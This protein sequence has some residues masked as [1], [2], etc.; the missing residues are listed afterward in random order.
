IV[1]FRM[2]KHAHDDVFSVLHFI[3]RRQGK[4]FLMGGQTV[5][6]LSELV[7]H[8]ADRNWSDL[9][10]TYSVKKREQFIT[11][12]EYDENV[13]SKEDKSLD[14]GSFGEVFLGTLYRK[15]VALK[16][17]LKTNVKEEEFL[18]EAEIARHCKHPNVLE[19]IGICRSKLCIITEYMANGSLKQYMQKHKLAHATCKSVA[20]KVASAMEFLERRKIVHRDLAA[21]NILVGETIEIIKVADFGLA[22]SLDKKSFY[23][24]Y[25]EDFPYLW[26]APEGFV[27]T[28]S[29]V[30]T[31]KSSVTNALDVWSFGVIMW[32]LYT[33]GLQKPYIGFVS[34]EPNAV[35]SRDKLYELLTKTDRRLTP[36]E[37]CPDK[38]QEIMR[39]CWNLVQDQRPTFTSI[40]EAL[41]DAS[42][43]PI[44]KPIA[45]TKPKN[46]R[47][48]AFS[49]GNFLSP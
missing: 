11:R 38:I 24:S 3:I 48:A 19:T 47:P 23:S 49:L 35:P 9:Q 1:F 34:G 5:D 6:T 46:D 28:D 26:S 29:I 45:A 8:Y 16:T 42:S 36:P 41:F 2:R 14:G 20:H 22:R 13:I 39:K 40:R 30:V 31:K 44:R 17:P 32:E 33:N 21:R 10:L 7:K 18:K 15:T 27:I 12:W 37:D 4:A 43:D 25:K